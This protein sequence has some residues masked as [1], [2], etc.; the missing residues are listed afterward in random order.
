M[1]EKY[2]YFVR[3]N[4]KREIKTKQ[5]MIDLFSTYSLTLGNKLKEELS[6][7][8]ITVC[9]LDDG[10]KVVRGISA[11]SENDVF[12]MEESMK[13]SKHRALRA[14]KGR[15]DQGVEYEKAIRI[16]LNTG[17]PFTKFS[18]SNPELSFFEKRMMY[19]KKMK[20]KTNYY[21]TLCNIKIKNC[22]DNSTIGVSSSCSFIGLAG[23]NINCGD[24]VIYNNGYITK[25][26]SIK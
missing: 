19:G 21:G 2:Y 1:K 22:I 25:S 9:L 23:E 5:G 3:L 10:S 15:K 7:N 11:C 8:A 24:A 20:A 13:Y 26:R 12:D 4:G 6:G 16:F 17:C 18:D 14:L